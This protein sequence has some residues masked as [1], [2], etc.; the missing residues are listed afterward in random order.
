MTRI[1]YISVLAALLL[2]AA[3]VSFAQKS[4][5]QITPKTVA[6]I[7]DHLK[8]L[9]KIG[10]SGSVLIAFY[11]RPVISSGYGYSDGERKLK[12][13]PNTI[14]DIGSVT[15][16][17]TAAAILK[18]EMQGNLSTNDEISKYFQNVPPDKSSIT[19]HQLLRHSSGLTGGVGGDYEKINEAAFVKKYLVRR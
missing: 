11:G 16:Q 5:S 7:E 10:Y 3:G 1:K 17:F 4:V 15:K 9:D 6:K 8:Q 14:F 19:I 12:N 13:S 2:V 18:L